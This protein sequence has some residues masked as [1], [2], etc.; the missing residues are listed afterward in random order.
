MNLPKIRR[1]IAKV[2]AG[3][4]R[5]L[6]TLVEWGQEAAVGVILASNDPVPTWARWHLLQEHQCR[7]TPKP[8]RVT[9]AIERNK[10]EGQEY[11][12]K[13]KDKAWVIPFTS[14]KPHKRVKALEDFMI[15]NGAGY[16][17]L[18]RIPD[19]KTLARIVDE[20]VVAE[21]KGRQ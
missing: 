14:I 16:F 15:E 20:L 5:A 10:A 18:V 8:G 11:R 4:K 13:V 19:R 7:H 2:Q 12:D 6:A 3:D 21:Q 9:A 17:G 1:L